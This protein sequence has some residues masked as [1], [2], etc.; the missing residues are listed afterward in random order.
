MTSGQAGTRVT[1]AWMRG[2]ELLRPAPKVTA[3]APSRI[4]VSVTAVRAGRPNGSASPIVTARG[5]GSRA[6]SR[7]AARP[8]PARGAR[9]AV[10][11]VTALNRPARRAGSSAASPVSAH[12]SAG[13]PAATP[14]GRPPS[15]PTPYAAA[16]WPSTSGPAPM[17]P[18]AAPAR[19]PAAA[20]ITAWTTYTA[21]TWRG[22]KPMDLS[23]P[24]RA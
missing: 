16:A 13:A 22:V 14:A 17:T 11:A 2:K 7:C 18:S 23:T 24:I 21:T 15:V 1:P 5:S 9:P 8:W 6:A 3:V 12:S 19:H 10:I 20:G 4:T